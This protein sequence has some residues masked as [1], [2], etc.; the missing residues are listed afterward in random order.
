MGTERRDRT[1][2][3]MAVVQI[4]DE[5]RATLVD[6]TPP[7]MDEAP[8][9]SGYRGWVG[10]VIDDKYRLDRLIAEGGMG[11]VYE[12]RHVEGGPAV[13]L[14]VMLTELGGDDSIVQRFAREVQI[15]QHVS[16][17][18][19]VRVLATGSIDP[20]SPYLVLELVT[21]PTLAHA[22]WEDG[23]FPWRRAVRVGAQVAAGIGA[24][25]D[26]GFVHRDLKPDNVV[27]EP[28]GVGG[29]KVKLLDFGIAHDR[30][31]AGR[32][33]KL[34]RFG[35]VLGTFGYMAPEQAV[36][37]AVDVRSDLYAL[38]VLI[39]EMIAGFPLFDE[40]LDQRGFFLAQASN[41]PH[42]IRDLA[43]DAP[44]GLTTLVASLLAVHQ[45]DR[46]TDPW[47]V[48]DDLL[49]LLAPVPTE[50][51]VPNRSSSSAHPGGAVVSPA[52]STQAAPSVAETTAAAAPSAPRYLPTPTTPAPHT[53]PVAMPE[54]A[55]VLASAPTPPAIAI[56]THAPASPEVS[57]SSSSRSLTLVLAGVGLALFGGLLC[58]VAAILVWTR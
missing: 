31:E 54:P 21:G 37:Q 38:G 27:L 17:E 6:A 16:H 25:W 8:D 7:Q 42:A 12:A 45:G 43:P 39:W 53:A 19:V 41:T 49:T 48:R 32:K 47:A 15:G 55:A 18:N 13:A 14:K 46:P 9:E 35:E 52:P 2:L 5:L 11:A 4:P 34:T 44:E 50:H 26:A 30:S 22:M 24:A 23:A 40:D 10:R 1:I 58:L 56:A 57:P 51:A 36:G 20:R 29:E 3:G 33:A 28:D